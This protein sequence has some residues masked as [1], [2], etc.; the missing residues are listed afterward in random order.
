[1]HALKVD[2]SVAWTSYGCSGRAVC[3]CSTQL[4]SIR[5][6]DLPAMVNT[7]M[8]SMLGAFTV[9]G[10]GRTAAKCPPQLDHVIQ[11]RKFKFWFILNPSTCAIHLVDALC[12]L[13]F[14]R[15]LRGRPL[16]LRGRPHIP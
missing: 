9:F 11:Q 1:M 2:R 10:G 14:S 13:G 12:R 16:A 15:P 5:M 3:I 6:N 7:M 4:Y 8:S